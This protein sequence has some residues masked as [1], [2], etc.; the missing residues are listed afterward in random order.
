ME[1]PYCPANTQPFI[2][3]TQVNGIDLRII[4]LILVVTPVNGGVQNILKTLD[5]GFRRNDALGLCMRR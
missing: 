4:R 5:S 2:S 3:Y 1:R